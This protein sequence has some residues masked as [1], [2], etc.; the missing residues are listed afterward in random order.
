MCVCTLLKV[1][2]MGARV[3]AHALK[4]KKN[5]IMVHLTHYYEL[6][7]RVGPVAVAGEI[8]LLL[9]FVFYPA[10]RYRQ[11]IPYNRTLRGADRG[12]RKERS[13]ER[14]HHQNTPSNLQWPLQATR[15]SKEGPG[16]TTSLS[17]PHLCA[18]RIEYT[19]YTI[20]FQRTFTHFKSRE[21]SVP[22]QRGPSPHV[23][24]TAVNDRR[25]H[26]WTTPLQIS[27]HAS[28]VI[29]VIKK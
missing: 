17:S 12:G 21:R 14:R 1:N 7:G 26:M 28:H 8:T 13:W 4:G 6:W 25:L 29:V 23:L 2:Q 24:V 11:W 19:G 9:A 16:A 20:P 5:F 27:P 15:T 10:P 22:V 18:W 3:R